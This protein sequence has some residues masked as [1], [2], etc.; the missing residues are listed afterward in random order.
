MESLK[1]SSR[2]PS[3][4]LDAELTEYLR[5]EKH[6]PSGKGTGNSRNGSSAKPLKSDYGVMSIEVPR[7]RNPEFEPTVVK[8]HQTMLG[9][10]DDKI[11]FMYGR[12]MSVW[13]SRLTSRKFTALR[14]LSHL[15]LQKLREDPGPDR[16]MA[17]L[18]PG[19]GLPHTVPGRL[20]YKVRENGRIVTK[21]AYTCLGIDATRD[22][23]H[24]LYH[25]K[26]PPRQWQE[27]HQT[28]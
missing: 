24:H 18:T 2:R 21:A 25:L 14:G 9:A 3:S 19:G 22:P 23:D 6:S 15:H 10:L 20:H 12:W 13:T 26:V 27:V 28:P 8:K 16:G 1:S 11:I 5:Y 7:D 17:S 4:G